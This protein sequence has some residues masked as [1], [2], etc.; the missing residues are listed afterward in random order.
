[1]PSSTQ[2]AEAL[3]GIK[4][5]GRGDIYSTG[6]CEEAEKEVEVEIEIEVFNILN[7]SISNEERGSSGEVGGS[8]SLQLLREQGIEGTRNSN[9]GIIGT[10]NPLHTL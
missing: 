8:L 2:E 10:T 5:Q 3:V 1:M 6:R 7:N 4:G 9:E